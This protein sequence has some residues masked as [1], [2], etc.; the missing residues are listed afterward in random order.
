MLN[1]LHPL[2][3]KLP[4]TSSVLDVVVPRVTRELQDE[5]V[6]WV[7]G[8]TGVGTSAT[9]Y[10]AILE[11]ELHPEHAGLAL[12]ICYEP[13]P[14]NVLV[15]K[16]RLGHDSRY[17]I[18]DVAVA[19]QTGTATFTVPSRITAA[20]AGP[21]AQGTSFAG[22]LRHGSPSSESISV[23]TVRLDEESVPRFDFVK[24]DLQGAEID[25]IQGMGARLQEVKLFYVETQLLHDWGVLRLLNEQGFV[26]LFD[27]LQFGFRPDLP[28]VPLE[29]LGA[30]GIAID[31]IHLPQESGMPLICWGHFDAGA[32]MLDPRSFV[33]KSEISKKLI[34]GG[35]TYLQTDAL[36]IN[37]RWLS[38]I[39]PC[40]LP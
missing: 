37:V 10:A 23:Q 16:Q 9:G 6:Y 21:W 7:D 38:R 27:R 25:A 40:L 30:C 4:T 36:A 32:E 15:L 33:L 26:L 17:L 2:L 20:G 13:L 35:V 34:D 14:E 8:G 12:V 11:R 1:A 29:L 28:Y 22:S 3:A 31:R 5:F 19:S 24:L 39:A 18:R